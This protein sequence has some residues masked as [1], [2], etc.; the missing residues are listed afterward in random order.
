MSLYLTGIGSTPIVGSSP[1][2]RC[3]LAARSFRKREARGSSPRR[4]SHV[5]VAQWSERRPVRPRVGGSSPSWN[6]A[7]WPNGEGTRLFPARSYSHCR[8]ESCLCSFTRAWCSGRTAGFHP[9]GRGSSPLARSA[10]IQSTHA[11]SSSHRLGSSSARGSL[12]DLARSSAGSAGPRGR[13]V[14]RRR[15]RHRRPPARVSATGDPA[16]AFAGSS[17]K[18]LPRFT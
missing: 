2:R 6:A 10:V 9:V 1:P 3:Q 15:R 11:R 4:G 5:P 8:F 16:P 18:G 7:E 12:A 13:R 14:Q 17:V